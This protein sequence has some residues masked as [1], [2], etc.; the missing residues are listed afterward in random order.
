[1]Y[2]ACQFPNINAE[3]YIV[4]PA[5]HLLTKEQIVLNTTDNINMGEKKASGV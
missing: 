3:N 4:R 5:F 2:D 1:M